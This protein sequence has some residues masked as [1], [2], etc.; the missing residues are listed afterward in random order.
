MPQ[1]LT[2]LAKQL[3]KRATFAENLL[4]SR[5]RSKQ[6]EGIKFR[7]QQPLGN[8]IVDFVSLEA[9]VVIELDGGQHA[10]TRSQDAARDRWLKSK[11]FTVLR[12]WNNEVLENLEGVLEVVWR[13]CL[14][15]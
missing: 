9:K 14:Y 6:I 1:N 4:W 11:G 3:R 10:E 15:Q 12:F 8:F 2:P 7:R 5:L 13:H